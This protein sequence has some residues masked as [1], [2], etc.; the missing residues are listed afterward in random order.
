MDSI[1]CLAKTCAGYVLATVTRQQKSGEMRER[2]PQAT[3]VVLF[4]ES[5]MAPE[6]LP[7]LVKEVLP[8]GARVNQFCRTLTHSIGRL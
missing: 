8:R 7:R 2:H 3:L 1:A 4:G 6:H 5:H